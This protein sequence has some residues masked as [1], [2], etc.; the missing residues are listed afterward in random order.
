MFLCAIN[1]P[2]PQCR[3]EGK[4]PTSGRQPF[5][6][7]VL[8]LLLMEA[9]AGSNHLAEVILHGSMSVQGSRAHPSSILGSLTKPC[10]K[11]MGRIESRRP[12]L[13]LGKSVAS[14]E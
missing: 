2:Y 6:C 8:L 14:Q 4:S 5:M 13:G 7:S 3:A 12:C 9:A 10:R 1:V 11:Q